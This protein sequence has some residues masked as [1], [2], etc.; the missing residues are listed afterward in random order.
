[1]NIEDEIQE[2]WRRHCDN[3]YYMARHEFRSAVLKAV[4]PKWQVYDKKS[5]SKPPNNSGGEWWV[6]W[7]AET[8]V[9]IRCSWE[10]TKINGEPQGVFY[11]DQQGSLPDDEVTHFMPISKPE[12]PT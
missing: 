3:A 6:V 9:V 7:K 2:L 8:A 5:G 12:L 11:F 4:R 10:Y 1:M